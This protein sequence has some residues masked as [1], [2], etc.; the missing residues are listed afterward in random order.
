MM[1]TIERDDCPLVKGVVR[2]FQQINGYARYDK[3][4]PTLVHYTE[5]SHFDMKGYMPAR[6]FNMIIASLAAK[7]FQKLYDHL[8]IKK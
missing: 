7:E 5:I 2:M 3:E 8:K 6:L 1:T 4:D